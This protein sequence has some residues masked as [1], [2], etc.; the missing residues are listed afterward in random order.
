MK[1][2]ISSDNDAKDAMR[3]LKLDSSQ[4]KLFWHEVYG[5]HERFGLGQFC[6]IQ[7]IDC[8]DFLVHSCNCGNE[9]LSVFVYFMNDKQGVIIHKGVTVV[10]ELVDFP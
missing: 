3:V 7:R 10:A 1:L 9:C 6:I 5:N 2:S 4:T 8:L